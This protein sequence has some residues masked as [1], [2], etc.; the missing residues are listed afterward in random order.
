M[1]LLSLFLSFAMATGTPEVDA[2]A[3]ATAGPVSAGAAQTLT[4]LEPG[5]VDLKLLRIQPTVGTKG[6][7]SSTITMESTAFFGENEMPMATIPPIT[8]VI[9]TEV[10]ANDGDTFTTDFEYK[11]V[12]VGDVAGALGVSEANIEML[13]A[14]TAQIVGLK[15]E[16]KFTNRGFLVDSSFD[17]MEDA[18]KGIQDLAG[19]MENALAQVAAPFPAEPVG[20]GA[21]WKVESQVEHNGINVTQVAVYILKSHHLGR[22]VME[23]EV[24][25][26]AAEQKLKTPQ[27]DATLKSMSSTGKGTTTISFS[28]PLPKK[29]ATDATVLIKMNMDMGGQTVEM[30]MTTKTGIKMEDGAGEW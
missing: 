30:D 6:T 9:D 1:I 2:P 21:R 5:T 20:V 18:S 28:A 17:L 26:S 27:G 3:T 24:T 19:N 14:T 8:I 12:E 29:A 16:T 15:G 10:T 4:L 25:Q 11:S 22:A 7:L 13:K 23:F